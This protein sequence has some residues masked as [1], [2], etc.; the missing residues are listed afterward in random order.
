MTISQQKWELDTQAYL[1]VCNITAALPRQ[2]IYEFA[3]GVNNLG[4]WN[5]MVCWPL[6]SSQNYG[7]GTTA[8]SLGGLGTF[9]GTLVNGPTFEAN[10]MQFTNASSQYVSFGGTQILGGNSDYTLMG[11]AQLTNVATINL[12]VIGLGNNRGTNLHAASNGSTQGRF[13]GHNNSGGPFTTQLANGPTTSMFSHFAAG[14]ASSVRF[15][16]NSGT[17][18]NTQAVD[19]RLNPA[20]TQ[21]PIIGG[22]NNTFSG[23]VNHWNGVIAA[24]AVWNVA[25]TDA[26][27]ASVLSLYK[28]T[29]GQGLLLP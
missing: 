17:P 10:G 13:G 28:T 7:S 23:V 14:N 6:R 12:S 21:V 3:R 22:F 27:V 19:A 8:F 5:S 18:F 29:L 24:G 11:V 26:Q 9:N 15:F 25:L 1:N 20:S 2:Q 16:M 4:L